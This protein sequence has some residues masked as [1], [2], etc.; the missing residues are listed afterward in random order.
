MRA[1]VISISE[2]SLITP[3]C[4]ITVEDSGQCE[5]FTN[6]LGTIEE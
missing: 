1:T 3:K 4:R 2:V 5:W 6:C